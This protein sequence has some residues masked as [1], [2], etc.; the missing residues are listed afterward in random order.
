MEI[1]LDYGIRDGK[2]VLISEIGESER[3]EKCNCNCPYCDKPLSAKLGHGGRRKHFAHV[4][5]ED[6]D[7]RHAQETGLHR[8]AKEILEQNHRILLPG[9]SIKWEEILPADSDTHIRAAVQI[10]LPNIP[11]KEYEYDSVEIEKNIGNVIA[12]A[13]I[14]IKGQP[15]IVEVAV[16]HFVDDTKRGKAAEIAYP[17]FEIDISDLINKDPSREKITKAVLSDNSNRKWIYNQRFEDE[18]NNKKNEFLDKYSRIAEIEEE[19]KRAKERY[20]EERIAALKE[21]F[22]Q[23]K[24]AEEIRKLR[25]DE[26][27]D[28]WL[29][30]F[31]FSK[32]KG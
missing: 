13:V 27:A 14:R 9:W 21:A 19:K 2:T 8:L 23:H 4:S 24:Y 5:L 12:D 18:L 22:D 30:R 29:R 6:C 1:Q 26:Q 16:T 28:Y 3:G 7:I 32:G 15:C 20:K 31:D 11:A 25:N 10:D 17:M